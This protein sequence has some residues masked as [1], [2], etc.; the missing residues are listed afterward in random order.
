M[1]DA[2][3]FDAI[4]Q[5]N[6][7]EVFCEALGASV[8]V[9]DK[10]DEL[11]F[12]SVHLLQL[13]PVGENAI[14]P[15]TRARDLYGALFDAGCRFD[16]SG[17]Y[18]DKKREDWIAERVARAWKERVDVIEQSGPDRWFRIVSRRFSSGLGLTV[19]HDVSEHKKKELQW[20]TEHERVRMTEEILDTL[21]VAIAIKDRNLNFAAVNQQFCKMLKA[22][23]DT[24]LGRGLGDIFEP[25]LA[26]SLEEADWH[27]LATGEDRE[28][29]IKVDRPDDAPTS[30]LHRARRIGKAGNHYISMS[31]DEFSAGHTGGQ[32]IAVPDLTLKVGDGD[33]IAATQGDGTSLIASNRKLELPRKVVY[34][35]TGHS[36]SEIVPLARLRGIELCIIR[37]ENEFTAFLPAAKAAGLSLDLVVIEP[38]AD[39]AFA[40]LSAKHGVR[41]RMLTPGANVMDSIIDAFERRSRLPAAPRAI[42]PAPQS[43]PSPIVTGLDILAIEDNPVNSMVLEQILESLG[44]NFLIVGSGTQAIEKIP[45]LKPQIVLVDIT[46]PDMEIGD[47]MPALEPLLRENGINPPVIGL[48]TKD[49]ADQRQICKQAGLADS[50][51]KP[52][53][54][55]AIDRAL[56]K[57]LFH[58]PGYGSSSTKSAA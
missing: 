6:L 5:C 27:L 41:H 46:L 12:A 38:N 9:T 43:E 13:F 15:G 3:S 54:P 18:K 33:G 53:S 44:L 20:R 49:G 48:I 7:L 29:I 47:F 34:V 11:T 52:L 39:F 26:G 56:R 40:T 19:I 32:T 4:M 22:T 14:K 31:F 37:S 45:Q 23:P 36:G 2:A 57:H 50:I 35:N 16:A 55:E 10:L 8:L 58:E 21:P 42:A 28:T 24:I 51:A 30:F 17:G 1:S 25:G